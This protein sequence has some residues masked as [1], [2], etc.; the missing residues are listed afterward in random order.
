MTNLISCQY[1]GLLNIDTPKFKLYHFTN[2]FFFNFFFFYDT[3]VVGGV[4]I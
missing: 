4:K 3:F 2:H 1:N